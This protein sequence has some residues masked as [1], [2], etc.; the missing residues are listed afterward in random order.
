MEQLWANYSISNFQDKIHNAASK[1]QSATKVTK[2]VQNFFYYNMIQFILLPIFSLQS[3]WKRSK[4]S[5]IS[6]TL[7][8]RRHLICLIVT[9]LAL[10]VQMMS[11]LSILVSL[12]LMLP[13]LLELFSKKRVIPKASSPKEAIHMQKDVA[14][15][16]RKI[17]AMLT[18]F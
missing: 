15:F 17:A 6:V 8:R 3:N 4:V 10:R 5:V 9:S 1:C 14:R 2:L 11:D 18:W 16:S 7:D 13:E 12:E